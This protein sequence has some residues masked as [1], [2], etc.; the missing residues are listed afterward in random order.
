MSYRKDKNFKVPAPAVVD[1]NEQ[2]DSF[3]QLTLEVATKLNDRLPDRSEALILL[4]NVYGDNGNSSEAM[5]YWQQAL[6]F[7]SPRPDV[8]EA[9]GLIAMEKGE[10]SKAVDFWRESL[11]LN[12]QAVGLRSSIA[13]ALMRLGQY[14][15][16]LEALKEQIELYPASGTAHF[17]AGQIFLQKKDYE[18][19]RYEYLKV[20]ELDPEHTNSYYGLLTVCVRLGEKD[21]AQDYKEKFTRC[22]A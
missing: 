5:R 4:G 13:Q 6:R 19:A 17:L 21:K 16:A 15:E 1:V 2:I 20:L 10:Y 7:C 3:K 12:H 18:R 14:D 8:Y 22:K 9:M 11:N